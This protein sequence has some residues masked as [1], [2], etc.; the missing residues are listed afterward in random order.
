MLRQTSLAAQGSS[1]QASKKLVN[2]VGLLSSGCAATHIGRGLVVT[3]GHCVVPD[4]FGA[5]L[6]ERTCGAVR[7][8]WGYHDGRDAYLQS[9]CK[10]VLRSV[11]DE[12]RDYALLLVEP[13]PR[14]QAQIEWGPLP[15]GAQIG[16]LEHRKG[17]PLALS[18]LYTAREESV[19][20]SG[21]PRLAYDCSSEKGSS[22]SPIIDVRTGTV[23]GI[24]DGRTQAACYGTWL[25]D[26]GLQ[27]FL[28]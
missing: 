18:G 1:Y 23:V 5:T 27:S 12:W 6:P 20:K 13:A 28:R 14:A 24:H 22:G 3:A 16:L 21:P 2:A 17:R 10:K 9:R 7:V 26:T 15:D 8:Y 11:T 19:V 4:S 25:G